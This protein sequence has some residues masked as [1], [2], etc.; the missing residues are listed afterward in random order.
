MRSKEA[1]WPIPLVLRLGS[2]VA[3]GQAAGAARELTASTTPVL[4]ELKLLSQRTS[5]VG[6][7][8]SYGATGRRGSV[9]VWT[10]VTMSPW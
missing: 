7:G 8:L 4:D 9:R 3:A 2:A 1:H 5:E 10:T 6:G